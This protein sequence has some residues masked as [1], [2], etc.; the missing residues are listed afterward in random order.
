MDTLLKNGQHALSK[1]GLPIQISGAEKI[2]QQISIR[3]AIRK[4]SFPYN[5]DLG[6]E[7]Y[8]LRTSTDEA[9]QREAFSYVQEALRDMKDVEVISVKCSFVEQDTL[10]VKVSISFNNKFFNLEV[11]T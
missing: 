3:L 10:A 4:G 1:S 8:K 6:S 7:L 5:K 11:L 2:L 9:T